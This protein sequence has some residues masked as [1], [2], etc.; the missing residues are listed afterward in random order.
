V[1][2]KITLSCVTPYYP[3]SNATESVTGWQANTAVMTNF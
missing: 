1:K 2:I 3:L